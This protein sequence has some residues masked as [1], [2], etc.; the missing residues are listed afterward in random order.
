MKDPKMKLR[1]AILWVASTT[2]AV[3]WWWSADQAT[4]AVGKTTECA[5]HLYDCA[6]RL[7]Q[8]EQICTET[9]R[10]AMTQAAN[11]FTCEVEICENN[12]WYP[13]SDWDAVKREMLV[14]P[15]FREALKRTED[16]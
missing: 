2:M 9:G 13:P 4:K 8:S 16:R 10:A 15:E 5:H 1:E 7:T 3:G 12:G 11:I 14:D 6:E